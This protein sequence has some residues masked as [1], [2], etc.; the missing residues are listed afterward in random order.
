MLKAIFLFIKINFLLRIDF[1]EIKSS[2]CTVTLLLVW[3]GFL[4][5]APSS[6]GTILFQMTLKFSAEGL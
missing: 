1:I 6:I 4:K 3:Y 2:L 5:L